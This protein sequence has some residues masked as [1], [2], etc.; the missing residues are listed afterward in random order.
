MLTVGGRWRSTS[1]TA[2][3]IIVKAP[4]GEHDL[5]CGGR[6]MV[7]LAPGVQVEIV[8]E[9]LAPF[10]EGT[11]MGKRYRDTDRGIEV[12]CT[13][14]GAGS[15]ALDGEAIPPAEAKPLPSSD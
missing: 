11:G 4:E 7:P 12:L 13:K 9:P 5:T 10:T 2:E 1:C 14:A 3:V 15:L 6:P 8:G